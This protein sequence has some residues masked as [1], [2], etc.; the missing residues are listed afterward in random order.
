M[1]IYSHPSFLTLHSP[2]LIKLI[3][4]Q[5]TQPKAREKLEATVKMVRKMSQKENIAW[6]NISLALLIVALL[7]FD[8]LT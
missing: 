8:T 7:T 3:K 1:V 2:N 6:Y 5:R 4:K